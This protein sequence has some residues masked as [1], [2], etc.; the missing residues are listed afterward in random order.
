LPG[1]LDRD[2]ETVLC[3]RVR[4]VNTAAVPRYAWFRAAWPSTA[5]GH[6]PQSEGYSLDPRTGFTV[7]PGGRVYA[8]SR[9]DGVPVSSQ[10]MA[11]LVK[12]G[13]AATYELLLPHRPIAAERAASLARARFEER[14]AE[15]RAYWQAKLTAAAQVQL[16]EPR[17][18]EMIRAGLL[19]LDL[20]AYGREPDEP[21]AATIGLYA[22][23]GSETAP[24]VQFMDSMGWHEEARRSL[25]YFLDKQHDDG[26]MQNF[27]GYMLETGAVL[28]SLGEHYR[29]TRDDAWVRSVEPKLAKAVRFIL[30]WRA[31]NRR[32]ELKGKGYGMLEGKTADPNDPFRSFMLNGYHSLGLRRVAEMLRNVDPPESARLGREAEAFEADIR[33]GFWDAMARS[34]AVPLADGT[35]V[36]TL[37]PWVEHRGPLS[38]YADG[39]NWFTHG[40]LPVRDSLLGPLY[41]VFQEVIEPRS[42]EATFALRPT[43]S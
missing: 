41:A 16:P 19:H 15:C 21:L 12:P 39:G 40:A 14:H 38:L 31:R 23:I 9:L 20:V 36:P 37:P 6:T 7:F 42:T 4:A 11:I 24:I 26:F 25:T 30:D 34:P 13:E 43:K 28:W 2:E 17:L 29:Y 33:Q 5:G 10:E 1:E 18:Q 3:L 32:D 22:P 35:W 27:G 8:I